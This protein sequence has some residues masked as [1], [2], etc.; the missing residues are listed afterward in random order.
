MLVISRWTYA[1][2]QQYICSRVYGRVDP[3]GSGSFFD[4][5]NLEAAYEEPD[6][7][8]VAKWNTR[9]L[10]HRLDDFKCTALKQNG[11]FAIVASRIP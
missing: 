11:C 5:L 1:W 7:S 9:D 3:A 4:F 8:K 10:K 6:N 2:L